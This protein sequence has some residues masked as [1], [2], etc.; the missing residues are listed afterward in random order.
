[1]F[2]RDEAESNARDNERAGEG[3]ANMAETGLK[4]RKFHE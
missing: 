1:L 2:D 3:N 4:V